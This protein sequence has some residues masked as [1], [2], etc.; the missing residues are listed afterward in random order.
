MMRTMLKSKI[1]YPKV[2]EAKLHYKGSITIDE[3]LMTAA[4]IREHEQVS[5]LNM[6]N[7]ARFNTYAIKGKKGS[8]V[9]CLNGPAARL[10][11]KGD[12]VVIL[13]YAAYNDAEL[14]GFKS[15]LVEVDE[16]NKIKNTRLA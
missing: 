7:G 13:T 1:S 10:G 9:I 12:T 16:R 11:H 15:I 5:V 8:G 2:T 14:K 4:D 6:H 3:T